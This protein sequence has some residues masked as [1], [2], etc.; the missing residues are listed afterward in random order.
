MGMAMTQGSLFTISFE[1]VCMKIIRA[2][3]AIS[4]FLLVFFGLQ[5]LLMPKYASDIF[6]G[7]LIREYYFST[8][9]H[10]VIFIGDC[11]VFGSFS[12]ITLWEEFGITSFIRGS[13]Q[14]L[15]WQ[16]YYLL[17]ETFR[18]ETPRVIVLAVLAMQ[19]GEPQYEPYNRLTLDGMRWSG[20]KLRAVAASRLYDEDW[21]SYFFPILRYKDRW[22][23]LS[24]EDFRYFF[25][26]PRVSINGFM[27]RSDIA[28]AGWIPAPLP[29]ANL[30][31]GEMP[32]Y[33]LGRITALA[34]RHGIPLVLIK[35]P[36]LFPH[37][38]S[39]WNDQIV[40]FAEKN[41]LLFINFLEYIDVIG[42]DFYTDTFDGGAT[43]NVF[44]AEKLSYFFGGILQETF[45]L[46][47][48]RAEPET[49]AYWN[50]K[51]ELYH[52]IIAR[53]LEEIAEFGRILDFLAR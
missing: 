9:D 22:R 4:V 29:R 49:A 35:A 37:W 48:R 23:E 20:D 18:H 40:E 51:S 21:L 30:R 5:Q 32:Y 52:R 15:I 10:D 45:Q 8:K 33:Y 7:N 14:Q 13:A 53:Q 25:S 26:R 43:L 47:D 6:E 31:F 28:P 12:P 42:L 38:H 44:G 16:S 46:P 1:G 2:A 27:V 19:Y 36:T 39:E 17:R 34:E 3:T 24:S 50:E 11:E 41:N